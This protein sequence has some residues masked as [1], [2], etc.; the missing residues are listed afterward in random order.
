MA[1]FGC[2]DEIMKEFYEGEE[3]IKTLPETREESRKF[4]ELYPSTCNCE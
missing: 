1:D 4:M 3:R 2:P